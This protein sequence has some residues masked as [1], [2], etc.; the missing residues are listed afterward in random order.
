ML[1]SGS[2]LHDGDWSLAR[3]CITAAV[4]I[5]LWAMSPC[6]RWLTLGFALT[7]GVPLARADEERS[8]PTSDDARK[9]ASRRFADGTRA[10]DGG[11]FRRAGELYESAYQLSPHE[12]PLWNAA[13]AWHRAGELAR[14]AN[15]YARYLRVAPADARE[16]AKATSSLAQLATKL[17]RL[18]LHVGAGVEDVQVDGRPLDGP[19]VYVLPGTHVIRARAGQ[20]PLD[21]Q[22]TVRAGDA[23]SVVLSMPSSTPGSAPVTATPLAKAPEPEPSERSAS[24]PSGGWRGWSPVVVAVEGGVTLVLA[25]LVV[26]SGLDTMS[27]LREFERTPSQAVLESGRD[28]Q[29]RTNVL[30]GA[31]IGAA[32]ITAATAIWLTDWGRGKD[33]SVGVGVGPSGLAVRGGF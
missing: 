13:R 22:Q 16:R 4:V 28:Q 18:E 12:D 5:I 15:L 19:D 6:A 23:I 24:P 2:F 17:G 30:L 11:D 25:G 21:S 7:A 10:F 31:S 8:P 32:A 29:L 9:E 14:A 1:G 27:T 26:W 20:S 33:V 3:T